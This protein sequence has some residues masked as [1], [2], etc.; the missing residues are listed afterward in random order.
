M[1]FKSSVYEKLDTLEDEL[2]KLNQAAS[3][4][5]KLY[6]DGHPEEYVVDCMVSHARKLTVMFDDLRT[7]ILS[8]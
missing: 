7:A 2:I 6:V 3:L 8:P 1:N 5:E 4:A